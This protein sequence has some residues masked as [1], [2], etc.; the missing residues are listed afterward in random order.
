MNKK[1]IWDLFG[2][3]IGSVRKALNQDEYKIYTFDIL[4][5]LQ[6]TIIM[7]WSQDNII[8]VFERLQLPKPDYIIASPPCN[9]FSRAA[10]M[11]GGNG[12]W[13][14]VNGKLVE[15]ERRIY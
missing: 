5:T 9:S 3:G 11:K 12:S 15:R 13:R 10:A 2:G 7:D 1:I 6:D 14:N 8:E 4:N